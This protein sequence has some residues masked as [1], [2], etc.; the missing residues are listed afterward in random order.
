MNKR[1]SVAAPAALMLLLAGLLHAADRMTRFVGQ[2]DSKVRIEGSSTVHDWWV[3]GKLIEGSIEAGTGF[4]IEPGQDAK[5][6]KVKALVDI[7]IPVRSLKSVGK[8]GEAY[9]TNMDAAMYGKL[10]EQTSPRIRYHLNELLLRAAPK[11]ND[12]PYA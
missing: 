9:S 1:N 3:E 7:S 11:S 2:S 4:P 5:P 6:G 12:E 10:N 8:N